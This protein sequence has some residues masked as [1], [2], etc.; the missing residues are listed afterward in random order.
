MTA[1]RRIFDVVLFGALAACGYVAALAPVPDTVSLHARWEMPAVILGCQG[2]LLLQSGFAFN[3]ATL[4]SYGFPWVVAAIFASFSARLLV[5][6]SPESGWLQWATMIAGAAIFVGVAIDWLMSRCP[7]CGWP[8]HFGM[9]SVAG[10]NA[11][12]TAYGSWYCARCGESRLHE[13]YAGR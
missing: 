11:G 7:S 2:L 5:Y 6:L 12:P 10:F 1:I 3:L 13:A 4:V 8:R 9:R